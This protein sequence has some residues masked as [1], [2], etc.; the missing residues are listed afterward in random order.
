MRHIFDPKLGRLP[1]DTTRILAGGTAAIE[2]VKALENLGGINVDLIGQPEGIVGL[3]ENGKLLFDNINL[4]TLH[5]I[6]TVRGPSGLYTNHSFNYFITNYEFQRPYTLSVIG[7]GTAILSGDTIR[8]YAPDTPTPSGDGFT[9]NGYTFTI[10]IVE[11][12]INN[13][14]L[15]P[16][17]I[18]PSTVD[19]VEA[20]TYLFESTVFQYIGEDQTH[21]SSD[22][23]I[24]SDGA[25]TDVLYGVTENTDHKTTWT[26]LSTDIP[27]EFLPAYY[28]RVRHYGSLSGPSDWSTPVLFRILDATPDIGS[29][30]IYAYNQKNYSQ[31]HPPIIEFWDEATPME[32]I[33]QYRTLKAGIDGF[34]YSFGPYHTI[35]ADN[36]QYKKGSTVRLTSLEAITNIS[37]AAGKVYPHNRSIYEYNESGGTFTQVPVNDFTN[38]VTGL[39]S[40]QGDF[41]VACSDGYI[42]KQ[43]DGLGPYSAIS[44]YSAN[45]WNDITHNSVDIYA[46]NNT[47]IWKID[48]TTGDMSIHHSLLNNYQYIQGVAG[49]LY[50]IIDSCLYKQPNAIGDFNQIT[51]DVREWRGLA[52]SNNNLYACD[53]HT[54]Y[55]QIN[56]EGSLQTVIQTN[57]YEIR[58]IAATDTA[59]Y[60]FTTSNFLIK[61]GLDG[62][63]AVSPEEALGPIIVTHELRSSP[64][65]ALNVSETHLSTSWE[66]A[67]DDH[68]TTVVYRATTDTLYMEM[69]LASGLSVGQTYYARVKYHGSL[70]H[71]SNWSLP[72]EFYVRNAWYFDK[73]ETYS[74]IRAQRVVDGMNTITH[75]TA[76]N[77]DGSVVAIGVSELAEGGQTTLPAGVCIYTK[78]NNAWTRQDQLLPYQINSDEY[79]FFG[80]KTALNELGTRLF[81]SAPFKNDHGH[82]YTFNY[83]GVSWEQGSGFV[84]P[85]NSEFDVGQCFGASLACNKIGDRL[86][87][88]RTMVVSDN[89]R[90]VSTNGKVYVYNL[91]G[92]DTWSAPIEISPPDSFL[93]D[94]FGF[95]LCFNGEGTVLAIGAP[96]RDNGIGKVYIYALVGNDWILQTELKARKSTGN[97]HYGYSVALDE[98]GTILFVGAP[99]YSNLDDPNISY[100]N[101]GVVFGYKKDTLLNLW[102]EKIYMPHTASNAYYGKNISLNNRGDV[103]AVLGDKAYVYKGSDNNWVLQT[104]E[105]NNI[106]ET[107]LPIR[108]ESMCLDRLGST[109][110]QSLY[111]GKDFNDYSNNLAVKTLA[112]LDYQ[113]HLYTQWQLAKDLSF[114]TIVADSLDNFIDKERYS[115]NQGLDEQ[116]PFYIRVRYKGHVTGYSEWS[117][118]VIAMLPTG[119]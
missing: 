91:T 40:F 93:D 39:C 101:S 65:S 67:V 63:M 106:T 94:G 92:V 17:I 104:I 33:T 87:I 64:Y 32:R 70:G 27:S 15:T 73:A 103:L 22:W 90:S 100:N 13:V 119:E 58:G 48:A 5:P 29:P 35:V 24:A 9:L 62:E 12:I 4:S 6:P 99:D 72:Y 83:N 95:S 105:P 11:P 54:V 60:V 102:A 34:R 45:T 115:F 89:Y 66:I 31:I 8:Y 30:S 59:L 108:L 3:D 18:Q 86:A 114:N 23:E 68:F 50:A 82:V 77:L 80:Y 98:T 110:V 42:Y 1:N 111:Y 88:G 113:D 97:D 21:Q 19:I 28:I 44:T 118:L 26:V 49:S 46:C 112:I 74:V 38:V 47:E 85:L 25:F 51:Y 14:V 71:D 2:K 53:S 61:Y 79:T 76:S 75:S 52:S 16:S 84:D 109:I 116:V 55:K 117:H 107:P 10:T 81:V 78:T 7:N 57:E 56:G 41:Y 20:E 36:V 96:M 43:I 37:E 69:L